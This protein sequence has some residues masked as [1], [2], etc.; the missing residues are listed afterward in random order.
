MRNIEGRCAV[1][2]LCLACAAPVAAQTMQDGATAAA[3]PCQNI[4]GQAEIDGTMQQVT[5]LACQQPDGSW[6]FV[7]GYDSA[8][9]YYPPPYA[10]YD[11]WYWGAFVTVVGG[12]FIFFD[13]FHHHYPMNHVYFNRVS[14][15][16]GA[17][18]HGW[19]GTTGVH[20]GSWGA[21]QHGGGGMHR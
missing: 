1:L 19:H 5:G 15:G 3:P 6:Q 8:V 7:Q 10:Y 16:V 11:P 20:G 21:I 18:V 2:C 9:G 13:R 14:Y 12:S 4:A 17:R